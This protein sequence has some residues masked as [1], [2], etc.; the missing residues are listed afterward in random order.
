MNCKCWNF[1]SYIGIPPWY[2]WCS[3]M[4]DKS[5]CHMFTHHLLLRTCNNVNIPA[6]FVTHALMILPHVY[7]HS[8]L[9][10]SKSCTQLATRSGTVQ[11]FHLRAIVCYS[12]TYTYTTEEFVAHATNVNC[13][14]IGKKTSRVLVT[15]GE[16]HKVNMWAIGRPNA[17][18]VS[19]RKSIYW[20]NILH[21]SRKRHHCNPFYVSICV[22]ATNFDR[23]YLGIRVRWNQL[24]LIRLKPWSQQELQVGQSSCG[25]LKKRKVRPH[26]LLN[27]V[28]GTML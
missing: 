27:C 9:L 7:P 1:F 22:W 3:R 2:P 21:K 17:I 5:C 10:V 19:I 20:G 18:M 26:S 8:H 23:V 24:P 16:D 14:K 11:Q 28:E 25:I 13:L 4:G 15:G 12:F 6:Y